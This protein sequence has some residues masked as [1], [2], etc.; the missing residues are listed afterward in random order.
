MTQ[1]LSILTWVIEKLLEK[2]LLLLG[3]QQLSG[4]L[5]VEISLLGFSGCHVATVTRDSLSFGLLSKLQVENM[6]I[7][8][9]SL[10]KCF[11]C[12]I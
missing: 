5:L 7:E 11:C 8:V 10:F 12:R 2:L 1:T 6:L 3:S 4:K 9:K